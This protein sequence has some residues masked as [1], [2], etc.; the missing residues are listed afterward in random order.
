MRRNWEN[1]G[2]LSFMR[3]QNAF[4]NH[5][6]TGFQEIDYQ[7]Y[8]QNLLELVIP[9]DKKKRLRR[10]TSNICVS[11]NDVASGEVTRNNRLIVIIICS[12]NVSN[13]D[14]Y[15]FALNQKLNAS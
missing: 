8:L 2:V 13:I 5:Q 6:R 14:K 7:D 15:V 11:K 4:F 12:L 1:Y 9:N 10:H 3:K